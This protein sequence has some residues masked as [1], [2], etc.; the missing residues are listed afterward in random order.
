[1]RCYH[2]LLC[3]SLLAANAS[4]DEGMWLYSDPPVKELKAKYGFAPTAEWLQHLQRSSVRFNNGGSGSFVSSSGLVMTNHHVAFDCLQK[5]SNKQHNYAEDGFLAKTKLEELRC[6]DLEL[7][8]LMS[9]E[10]VTKQ[11]NQ[12]VKPQMTPEEALAARRAAIAQ[13]EKE[14]LDKTGL[15]SDVVTLFQGGR[16]DLYRYQRYTDVRLVWAPDR[17]AA[18]YGGEPDNFEYPRYALDAT[19]FRA[20]QDQK[21][22]QPKDYLKFSKAGAQEGELIFVSGHPGRTDRLITVAELTYHRDYMLPRVLD[23]L[24]RQEVLLSNYSERSPESARMA[25]DDL[26]SVKNSRKALDGRLA[27]LLTPEIMARKEREEALFKAAMALNSDFADSLSAFD[28]IAIAQKVIADN[29]YQYALLEAGQ[30]FNTRLF[31]IARM[32]LR[33]ADEKSKPN[34]ERL[35]EYA[36]SN[37]ASFELQLFSPEPIDE[38]LEIVKL[39]DSLTWFTSKRGAEDTLVKSVL[40]GMSPKERAAQLVKGTQLKDVTVR[41]K[42]YNGDAKALAAASDA[43]IQLALLV[44]PE[45]RALRQTIEAQSEVKQQAY[46]KLSKARF[47][48]H[49]GPAYPDATFT[50]RLAFGQ[51]KGYTAEGKTIPANTT[52]GGL[53]TYAQEHDNAAPY[54]LPERFKKQK[55]HLNLSTPYNFVSTA[56]IIGGNSGSPVVNKQGEVVGLIFDGNE[57]SLVLD[58]VYSDKTARAVSVHSAGLLEVLEKVYGGKEVVVELMG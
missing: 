56:D 34:G 16:Y 11:V 19:F 43:M 31:D 48:L 27:G 8:V 6:P 57:D 33:N 35:H 55:E 4:A 9:T 17:Q 52:L 15:R 24:R 42:L 58:Y 20:Y 47:A 50:V 37:K 41:R 14:S 12:A 28:E 54:N 49:K 36:D 44:D 18:A 38:N 13:I 23:F 51:V 29:A 40:A 1:M 53:Y 7:N 45:S 30:A 46:A 3:A 2:W 22:V 5:L 25:K 32:L 26:L 39:A 10:D 21:P